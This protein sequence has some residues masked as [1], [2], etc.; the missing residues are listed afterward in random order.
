MKISIICD[1]SQ[2]AAHVDGPVDVETP[3]DKSGPHNVYIF[4]ELAPGPVYN[5]S[6]T[7]P[8]HARYHT[9]KKD[10]GFEQAFLPL[11]EV[12][13]SCELMPPQCRDVEYQGQPELSLCPVSPDGTTYRL[14]KYTIEASR[15]MRSYLIRTKVTKNLR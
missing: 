7:L 11:P 3:A 5:A 6:V 9:A 13:F 8:I 15:Q 4:T 1:I 14:A 12:Y 10:G 2:L